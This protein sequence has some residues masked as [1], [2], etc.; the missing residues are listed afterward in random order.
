MVKIV[1]NNLTSKI[2]GYLSDEIHSQLDK[3]LS[4]KVLNA[5]FSPKF[6]KKQWDGI[7]RLYRRNYG[8][9]FYSGL[10]SYVSEILD[11][12]KIPFQKV[13]ERIKPIQ[14]LPHLVFSPPENYEER[15]YQQFTIKKAIEKTRGI[16]KMA[17]GSGKTVVAS[18][19]I[20]KIK[21]SPFMFY[22]LTEDLLRQAYEVLSSTLNEPIGM[23]GGGE[24]DIKNIN[25]CTIQTA[26]RALHG[27]EKIKI[28]DYRFDDEDTWSDKDL[29][30]IEKKK[31]LHKLI[32]EL[33]GLM[34]DETHHVA[35]RTAKEVMLAS[36][37]AFWRYG[38][39][40]TPWRE[41]GA[42]IIIQAMFGK[43]IVDV[44]ASYLIK[45]NYLVKPY[46]LFDPI[47]DD[48]SLH[49]YPSIYKQCVSENDA[50]NTRVAN[51]ANYLI[52]KGLSVLILVHQ[53]K[54]G[55]YI[56]N[57]LPSDIEF[58][59][60]KMNRNARKKSLRDIKEGK[61]KCIIGTTLFD[62]G[63]D[64]PCL[65]AVLMAGGGAS[66]TRVYQRIGRTLR[67]KG[68]KDKALVIYFEHNA[69][70]LEKHAK[71][72]RKIMKEEP[73]FE[74]IKSSGGDFIFDEIDNIYGY[75]SNRNDLFG[76]M[77]EL[78][79]QPSSQ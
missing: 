59:T 29:L 47:D 61:T 58:L 2:V 62:E 8:Q 14:N 63:V 13:D 25:V 35:N 3:T 6:K 44:S 46:I 7:I 27:G 65:D 75:S 28:S 36:P 39:S 31:A 69:K 4:Y 78:S 34:I 54:Q 26:I 74:I 33:N 38:L 37:N 79:V 53:Y 71:K 77:K 49:S 19:I 55:D 42:E 70:H 41:D 73:E 52:S 67:T 10:L 9:S 68:I 66:S 40:A 15:E 5:R 30:S 24:F 20:S 43:K 57:L 18:E 76:V 22:V 50:F 17:T 11:E 32:S 51:I 45:N 48:C 12:N 60:G 21:T 16:L 56:K 1:L 72:A 64:C 23:I